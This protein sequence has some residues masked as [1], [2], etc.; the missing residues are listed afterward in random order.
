MIRTSIEADAARVIDAIVLG[1]SADP[2]VRWLFPE[3]QQFLAKFPT[4]TRLFGGRAFE[5]DTAYHVDGYIGAALWLPPNVHPDEDGL[6]RS[7]TH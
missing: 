2:V 1:F 3:P 4:L 6:T 7:W 5:N